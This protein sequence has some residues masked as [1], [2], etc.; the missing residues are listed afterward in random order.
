MKGWLRIGVFG[1][2]IG[3]LASE[4]YQ[5]IITLRVRSTCQFDGS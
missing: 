1:L 2:I 3:E 4:Q 5:G